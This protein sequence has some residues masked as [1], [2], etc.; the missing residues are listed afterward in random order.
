MTKDLSPSRAALKS[1]AIP[2]EHGGWMFLLEPILLGL[3]VGP[4]FS[5]MMLAFAALG[6]FLTR[7][8]LKI[9]IDDRR[10]RRFFTRTVLA[11]RFAA[12]YASCAALA[13]MLAA[14]TARADFWQSLALA[15]PFALVQFYYDA[16]KRSRA[17]VAEVSGALA[18]GAVAPTMLL[19]AGGSLQPALTL[20]LLLASRA[21]TAIFYVRA[22]LRLEYGK[23]IRAWP[24][25]FIHVGAF[26]TVATLAHLER[27]PW[28]AAVA[29]AIL[30]ARALWGLSHR[31]KPMRAQTVGVHEVFYGI[32]TVIL[33]AAGYWFGI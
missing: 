31:R 2:S 22:R 33:I 6:A 18:L 23:S 14:I 17:A 30:L 1:V 20:W 8:P 24:V 11:E 29:L 13:F 26:M 25:W 9:A 21:I 16:T 27:V 3:S 4:S 28:L 5:G 12:G 32:L 19:M 10:K 7:H 15:L